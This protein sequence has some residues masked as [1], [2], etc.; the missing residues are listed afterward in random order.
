MDACFI[1]TITYAGEGWLGGQLKPLESMHIRAIKCLLGVR[2][3]TC[4]D[5]AL[6]ELGYASLD[7]LLLHRRSVYMKKKM[8][9]IQEN[10][11]LNQAMS[12]C[13]KLNTCCYRTLMYARGLRTDPIQED[14][15]LRKQHMEQKAANSS[16][17]QFYL[18]VNP[19]CS[20]HPVYTTSGRI[21]EQYRTAFT[22]LRLVSHNLKIETGRWSRIV[23][24][25]RTCQCDGISVQTE[26]HALFKCPLTR[27]LQ[28]NKDIHDF[29]TAFNYMNHTAV[30]SF[31][32]KVLKCLT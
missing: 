25:R 31:I 15:M 5:M 18:Q 10:D 2:A 26:H 4:T 30:C 13:E 8:L 20:V 29:T 11:P 21:P 19:E 12:L 6:L 23:R 32:Y 9:Y 16:K 22:R 27:H 28:P 3:T 17:R 24:E 14:I 1:S 7:K